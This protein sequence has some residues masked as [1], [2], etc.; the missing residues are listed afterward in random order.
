MNGVNC[1]VAS[2]GNYGIDDRLIPCSAGYFN[3]A[4]RSTSCFPC[5]A[6]SFNQEVGSTTCFLCPPG[7]YQLNR[8]ETTCLPCE[9][10]LYSGPGSD[11]VI[12]GRFGRLYCD[13][14]PT[15]APSMEPSS[16]P[17]PS[18]GP[19]TSPSVSNQP[20][21][22]FQPTLEYERNNLF[23]THEA[24]PS[25]PLPPAG[26]ESPPWAKP[27]IFVSFAAAAVLLLALLA[28][29]LIKRRVRKSDGEDVSLGSDASPADLMDGGDLA[30]E[31]AEQGDV[32]ND[33]DAP[34]A[35][36]PH[37]NSRPN[38][39]EGMA[40]V[41]PQLPRNRAPHPPGSPG[42]PVVTPY[43][44]NAPTDE[45][46]V[47]DDSFETFFTATNAYTDFYVEN[48][49]PTVGSPQAGDLHRDTKL[50]ESVKGPVAENSGQGELATMRDTDIISSNDAEKVEKEYNESG[51]TGQHK[52]ATLSASKPHWGD[53]D[54]NGLGLMGKDEVNRDDFGDGEIPHT[55]DYCSKEDNDFSSFGYPREAEDEENSM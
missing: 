11:S 24:T 36:R 49:F 28:V 44:A 10:T 25:T 30:L 42:L 47:P 46:K 14:R 50:N 26:L 35:F 20:T 22:S 54:G 33:A 21:E 13:K 27:Q 15:P 8:G 18:L 51:D 19:T 39:A 3:N 7:Y 38:L 16:S 2:P 45:T 12:A 41:S 6:G 43:E 4:Y 34:D 5:G 53:N 40:F 1:T 17:S 52:E 23:P 32:F 29:P 37:N 31:V 9:Q 48:G 55:S